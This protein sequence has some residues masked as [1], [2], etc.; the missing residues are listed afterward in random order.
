MW[1]R[2]I[3]VNILKR[4]LVILGRGELYIDSLILLWLQWS[5]IDF[6]EGIPW[7][8][9]QTHWNFQNANTQGKNKRPPEVLAFGQILKQG[10]SIVPKLRILQLLCQAHG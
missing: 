9:S 10:N 6:V 8:V 3:T 2:S 4:F 5:S 1:N 7:N